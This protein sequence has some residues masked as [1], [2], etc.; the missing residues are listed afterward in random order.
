MEITFIKTYNIMK[1]NQPNNQWKDIDHSARLTFS[2]IFFYPNMKLER[3]RQTQQ[4][5]PT[6]QNFV[7]SDKNMTSNYQL[8]TQGY[9]PVSMR[10]EI[11][12][13]CY[14]YLQQQEITKS[15]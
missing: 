10:N 14:Y 12:Q 8:N 9:L 3:P 5:S 2:T 13:P 15:N 6:R 7:Q 1:E 11:P 4:Q